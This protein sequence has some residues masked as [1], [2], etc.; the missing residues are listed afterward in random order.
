MSWQQGAGAVAAFGAGVANQHSVKNAQRKQQGNLDAL[1]AEMLGVL[2]PTLANGEDYLK[3]ANKAAVG[4]FDA[5][6]SDAERVTD[7]G[8]QNATLAGE[9]AQK[10]IRGSAATRGMS[11]SSI[12]ANKSFGA[13]RQTARAMTDAEIAGSR[14][15]SSALIGKG[16]TE[17]AGLGALANFEAYKASSQNAIL[18]KYWNFIAGKQFGAANNSAIGAGFAD[19]ASALSGGGHSQPHGGGSNNGHQDTYGGDDGGA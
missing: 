15:K 3:K 18:G 6:V 12:E 9:T 17:A 2:E 16:Q 4:G 1:Q 7:Q 8:V 11:G 13:A 14:L 19:F 5:A 10:A